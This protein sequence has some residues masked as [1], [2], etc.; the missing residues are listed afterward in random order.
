MAANLEKKILRLENNC[1]GIE[2][3][4]WWLT[5]LVRINEEETR[6]SGLWNI[7]NFKMRNKSDFWEK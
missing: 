7:L 6:I 5:F 1:T 2:K 3:R 4:S